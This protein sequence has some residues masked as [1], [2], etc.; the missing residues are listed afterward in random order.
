MDDAATSRIG[1]LEGRMVQEK[2]QLAAGRK[3]SAKFEEELNTR[4]EQILGEAKRLRDRL[5]GMMGRQANESIVF[6]RDRYRDRGR[7]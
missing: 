7:R 4:T 2:R 5:D 1:E 6:S 3:R